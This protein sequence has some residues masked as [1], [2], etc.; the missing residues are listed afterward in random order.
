MVLPSPISSARIAPAPQCASRASHCDAGALV[1]PQR[2]LQLG[3]DARDDRR[4][5][6]HAAAQRAERRC[7]LDLRLLLDQPD[8]RIA[9]QPGNV[10][11]ARR[12]GSAVAHLEDRG[13]GARQRLAQGLLDAHEAV[14][15][16]RHVAPLLA[17]RREQIGQRHHLLAA[18]LLDLRAA[19]DGEPVAPVGHLHA[20]V[21]PPD[22]A[23]VVEPRV[24]GPLDQDRRLRRRRTAP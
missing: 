14:R 17:D 10:Q 13:L 15:A 19:L 11:R 8:Q 9:G 7:R 12:S 22:R 2:R 18:P 16:D 6:A 24:V 5:L 3:A 20:H 21:A 1:G 4:A 23:V